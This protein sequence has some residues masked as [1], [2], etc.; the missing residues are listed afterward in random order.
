MVLVPSILYGTGAYD[1][2]D[3]NFPPL[4]LVNMWSEQSPTS[5][6]GKAL[7]SRPGLT[8]VAT[9]GTGPITGI[10]QE[11]GVLG[12]ALFAVT[13]GKLF[14]GGVDKGAIAGTGPVSFAGTTNELLI[15]AGSSLYSYNGTDLVAVAFPDSAS[16]RAIEYHD[17]LFIAIR[18]NTH[19]FYWSAV[20]NGRTWDALDFA[21][22][23][24]RPD[25]LLDL[26]ILNDTLFLFGE[27]TIEPWANVADA[28]A[29]YQRIEQRIYGVGL[30]STGC[31]RK[32]DNSLFFVGGDNV[33]Y[34]LADVP[35]R[36]SHHGIEEKIAGATTVYAYTF[37]HDGHSFFC[38]KTNTQ[39][40]AYDVATQQWAELQNTA[41]ANF[42]VACAT[43][44]GSGPMRMGDAV[45]GTVWTWGEDTDD[46]G[47]DYPRVF[48]A[49]VPLDAPLSVENVR[50]WVN[51]G[52]NQGP[53][54]TMEYSRDAG[55]TWESAGVAGMGG[56]GSYRQL[57]E[58]RA[59]GMFDFP[60]AMFRFTFRANGVLRVS[61]V[62]INERGGG[63]SR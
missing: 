36:I 30:H 50:L 62:K 4:K 8:L 37:I 49:A 45:D 53:V 9:W 40:F 21:S 19:K 23:E 32:L 26:K 6:E 22:A 52:Q 25:N 1:R 10:F 2:P 60:G 5:E 15:T 7:Q 35:E 41:D 24:S 58:W 46:N 27:E 18:N 48:T 14:T 12:G 39:T 20:L 57:V 3:G 61:A 42:N 54:I 55:Q 17:G 31:V 44:P 33:V 16:V 34:R 28:D 13:G 38:V 59:L 11:K 63:R 43:V 51:P 29:P 56:A 47:V